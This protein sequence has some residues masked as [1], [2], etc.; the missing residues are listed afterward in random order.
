MNVTKKIFL[1]LL[2]FQTDRQD[3]EMIL[4]VFGLIL[5]VSGSI[6]VNLAA[7]LLKL[8]HNEELSEKFPQQNLNDYEK[9]NQTMNNVKHSI[10]AKDYSFW[11][12]TFHA[13]QLYWRMGTTATAS[14]LVTITIHYFYCHHFYSYYYYY[15]STPIC[16]W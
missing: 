5:N 11:G 7:N 2:S 15:R 14:T 3:S 9:E 12:L 1:L 16:C 4:W 10:I 8:A 13:S 6:L